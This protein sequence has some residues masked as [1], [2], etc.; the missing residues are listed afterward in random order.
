M[1]KHAFEATNE[2]DAREPQICLWRDESLPLYCDKHLV[3][4]DG[5]FAS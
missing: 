2:K 4:R 1:A 3:A 5:L